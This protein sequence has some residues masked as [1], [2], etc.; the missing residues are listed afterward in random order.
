[1]AATKG[2]TKIDC[3]VLCKDKVIRAMLATCARSVGLSVHAGGSARYAV[4][5]LGKHGL[6]YDMALVGPSVEDSE[7]GR[8]ASGLVVSGK[9]GRVLGFGIRAADGQA[10]FDERSF[11]VDFAELFHELR[12]PAEVASE[13][14]APLSQAA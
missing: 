7:A 9:I 8:V 11:P 12:A 1:M 13:D 5:A 6:R 10:G 2:L 4:E 14:E 3:L